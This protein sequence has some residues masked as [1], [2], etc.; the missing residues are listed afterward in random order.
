MRKVI[1][2]GCDGEIG[3][4]DDSAGDTVVVLIT[5]GKIT[6]KDEGHE[7]DLCASCETKLRKEADPKQWHRAKERSAI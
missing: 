2:D 4:E 5:R 1:C 3:E 6:K 7:Y